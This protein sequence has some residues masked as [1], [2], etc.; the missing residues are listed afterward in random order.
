MT[1][2]A[3][4]VAA[5]YT[6]AFLSVLAAQSHAQTF[7][8][9][10]TFTGADGASPHGTLIM[11]RAGNLY[12]MAEYGG[13]YGNACHA[14]NYPDY[15]CGTAFKL[16]HLGS[17]WVLNTLYTFQGG[18]EGSHPDGFVVGP[19]GSFYVSTAAG[20]MGFCDPFTCGTIT[21][22]SPPQAACKSVVCP[23]TAKVLYR[24]SGGADGGGP[25]GNLIFDSKGKFYGATLVGGLGYGTVFE[26][27]PS[28]GSWTESVLW[29]FP[30]GHDAAYPQYGAVFDPAGN[31]YGTTEEG[32]ANHDGTVFQLTHSQG[33]GWNETLLYQ[34]NSTGD[35]GNIPDS[36]LWLDAS[37][38]LYGGT[39]TGGAGGCGTVYELMP[40]GGNW[41]FSVIQS[42]SGGLGCGG[43][44][45]ELTMDGAGNL[46]GVTFRSGAYGKGVVFKL[47]PA[48][49]GWTYTSL[50]DFTG[51]SDGALP[52]VLLIGPDGNLYGGA[53]AGAGQGC[54]GSGCG[55]LFEIT[56]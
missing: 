43:P 12:G 7:K 55:V 36:S 9:L 38:N 17:G 16:S 2:R 20:G 53:A 49:G 21:K 50:H 52:S 42:F 5:L 41:A 47:T 37:G 30:G 19:D 51:G 8:V 18:S 25:N 46:Y 6:L 1:P 24:F 33:G 29:A 44:W 14:R 56:P 15:G 10:H 22:L 23:W 4:K 13:K 27:S 40:Q 31:L 48:A 54:G 39:D 26:M 11:D 32:G 35:S 3:A 28:G 45:S 34:F